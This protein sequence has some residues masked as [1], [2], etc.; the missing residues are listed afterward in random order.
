MLTGCAKTQQK[1]VPNLSEYG[2]QIFFDSHFDLGSRDSDNQFGPSGTL[3]I[4]TPVYQGLDKFIQDKI[5]STIAN[6][7]SRFESQYSSTNV[8][9]EKYSNLIIYKKYSQEV[10]KGLGP[11]I[12]LAHNFMI[13]QLGARKD[14]KKIR[15]DFSG[16]EYMR[17]NLLRSLKINTNLYA[18]PFIIDVQLLCF[19][20][21]RVKAAPRTL[22]ELVELSKSG[23][24]VAIG[25][26]FLDTI[27]GLTDLKN[28]SLNSKLI[29]ETSFEDS[30]IRWIK[31]LKNMN[32]EPNLELF[33]DS[34][35]M[36]KYF[37]KGKIN[38]MNCASINLPLLRKEIGKENLGIAPLPSINGK[39]AT[40]RLTGASFALNP[41]MSKNQKKL[42]YHFTAFAVSKDQQQ[43]IAVSWDSV[44]PVNTTIDFNVPLLPILSVLEDSLENSFV[45]TSH[46][47]Q[48]LVENINTIQNLFEDATSGFMN[49]VTASQEIIKQLSR[50]Q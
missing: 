14:I 49:P 28:I 44:L 6:L 31:S 4:W 25:G 2:D 26:T 35:V 34:A 37:A 5:D 10:A 41:F 1:G 23:V 16:L 11:D 43:Q 38:V 15:S 32:L 50:K 18:I 9:W 30:L 12:I 21:R 8:I 42:A 33:K 40:P 45:L 13:P 36:N 46:E 48:V 24:S 29:S 27:W 3:V 22:E 39:A 47:F 17:K 20:K 7:V 19:D